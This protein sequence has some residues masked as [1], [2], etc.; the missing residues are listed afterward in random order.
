[1]FLGARNKI[2]M[3]DSSLFL[4]VYL[5]IYFEAGFLCIAVAVDV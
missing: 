3:K 4:D 5:F 1:M 2:K